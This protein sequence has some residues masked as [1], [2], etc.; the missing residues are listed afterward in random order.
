MADE[1]SRAAQALADAWASNV[2][3]AHAYVDGIAADWSG[4]IAHER[5]A[6][7]DVAAHEMAAL[8]AFWLP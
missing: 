3:A 7:G 5:G 6:L 2:D 1:R 8:E 4:F